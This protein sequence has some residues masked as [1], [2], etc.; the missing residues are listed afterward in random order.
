MATLWQ[1]TWEWTGF[2]GAPGYTNLYYQAQTA[3]GTEAASA[4]N[5]S[6]ALWTA[7][8]GLLPNDV[9]LGLVTDVRLL[10]D[11]DGTLRNIFTVSGTQ[12]VQ[13]SGG[14]GA[15][16]G[17]SGACIDWLTGV[18][19]GRHMLTGRTFI[20][21]LIGTCYESNGTLSSGTVLGLANAAESMR[22]SVG[23]TFG[24]WG[25]PRKAPT[26]PAVGPPALLGAWHPA[27]SSRV[28]DR[29]AVLRSRRQ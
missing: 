17:P 26:P 15:Y 28:V 8:A 1:V 3:D 25:R 12:A 13:G 5:K 6:R 18:T 22:N 20:V 10:E 11:T 7:L 24:V 16:S 21:P 27:I 19:H 14:V 29:A 4:V 23:P 9:N 2:T